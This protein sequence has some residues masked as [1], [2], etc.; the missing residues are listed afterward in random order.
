MGSKM[1]K[2]IAVRGSQNCPVHDPAEI[3]R[4]NKEINRRVA[5][6]DAAQPEFLRFKRL[7]TAGATELFAP[8]GNL[9][10]KNYS[11]AR[12]PSGE[13]NLHGTE[14]V[15]LLNCQAV[16]LQVLRNAVPQP[17]RDQERALCLQRQGPR[18]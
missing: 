6:L 18:V 12:F 7:G 15:R 5:E 8:Q 3:N 10:I 16:A 1:L 4:L 13:K 11:L 17:L 9:P 14:Y 2:G